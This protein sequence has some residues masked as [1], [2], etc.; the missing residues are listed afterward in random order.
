MDPIESSTSIDR[1]TSALLRRSPDN[2]FTPLHTALYLVAWLLVMAQGW[3]E[4]IGS[5]PTSLLYHP[6][7][8]S[9]RIV[10]RDLQIATPLDGGGLH[11]TIGRVIHDPLEEVLEASIWNQYDALAVVSERFE[12]GNETSLPLDRTNAR[13]AILL[14]EA[15][16]TEEA[17]AHM[18]AIRDDVLRT[19]IAAIYSDRPLADEAHARSLE[20][21]VQLAAAGLEEWML[22]RAAIR[23]LGSLDEDVAAAATAEL[24]EKPDSARHRRR[25]AISIANLLFV[26]LGALLILPLIFRSASGNQTTGFASTWSASLGWAVMVRAD[27]WNRLYFV[28]LR[29]LGIRLD[30]PDWLD[31]FYTWGTLIASLPMMW[32][33]YRHLLG[34]SFKD[35]S[36]KFGLHVENFRQLRIARIAGTAIAIDLMGVTAIGWGLYWLGVGGTWSEGLDETLIWGTTGDVIASCIDYLVWTPVFEEFMFRGLL[37]ITLRNRMSALHAAA[38]SSALFG[39]LH[40]YSFP[41]FLMTVWSGFVWAYAF[42]Y[43]RSLVPGI[44]AH[45]IYNLMFVLGVLIV[46]R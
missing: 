6:A 7:E 27:F 43:A 36:D 18:A 45:S 42:E 3:G 46:Y 26:T 10:N 30:H 17:R 15:G 34:S 25:D 40:F 41:G 12:A 22:E 37:F 31:P 19:A 44:A 24:V 33:V 14:E 4:Y 11:A 39:V 16:R 21:L 23:M 35:L 1:T 5:N 29:D 13:L 8:T 2:P 20:P 32:L 9:A 38:V 28:S